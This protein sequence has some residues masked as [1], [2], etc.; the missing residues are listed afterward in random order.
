MYVDEE[1]I[2]YLDNKLPK[3][4]PN[5]YPEP[6]KKH[7]PKCYYIMIAN[8]NRGQGKT[9]KCTQMIKM[10]EKWGYHNPVTKDKVEIKSYLFSPTAQS[11]PCWNALDSLDEDNIINDYT[12]DKLNE[13]I[14]DIKAE[15]QKVKDYQK[16]VEAYKRYQKMSNLQLKKCTDWDFLGLLMAYDYVDYRELDK[17][18]E[19]VYNI[20]LDDCLASKEAFSQKKSNSLT[21]L[22]LNSRHIGVNIIICCQNIKAITKSIRNNTDIWVLFKTKNQK[23]LIEDIYTEF[24]SLV[25]I[26]EFLTLFEKATSGSDHDALVIDA[27]EPMKEDRF[28]KNFDVILRLK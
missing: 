27:K 19:Y 13:I 4:K 25:T 7:I 5:L 2:D 24:S 21:R 26:D 28:K 16:Y 22:V 23:V 10:M 17:P 11:N 20:I 18:D 14:E 12:E 3:Y 6:N 9:I 8:G 1:K 15:R